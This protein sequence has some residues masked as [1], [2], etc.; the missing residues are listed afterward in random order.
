MRA[1]V[2]VYVK[3]Y[4]KTCIGWLFW[5]DRVVCISHAQ[6]QRWKMRHLHVD[7]RVLFFGCGTYHYI[8]CTLASELFRVTI[9]VIIV[10]SYSIPI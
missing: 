10:W 7:L 8:F 2:L 1:G 9:D 6:I 4:I 5:V 3:V